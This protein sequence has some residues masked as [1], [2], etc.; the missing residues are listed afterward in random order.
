MWRPCGFG[1]SIAA[2]ASR[3]AGTSTSARDAFARLDPFRRHVS[4]AP[5]YS[6]HEQTKQIKKAK[7]VQAEFAVDRFDLGGLDQPRMRH[8]HRVQRPLELLQPEIEEFVELGK[9]RAQI[10]LLP[11]IGLQK[12]PMIRPAVENVG[13]GQPISLE[14]AAEIPR[15]AV[16]CREVICREILF[17]REI[18]G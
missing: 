4:R 3:C 14:L 6:G 7:S 1:E 15:R 9:F 12:P 18:L 8:R 2:W 16:V 5:G 17:C 10:V 11:D 13:G